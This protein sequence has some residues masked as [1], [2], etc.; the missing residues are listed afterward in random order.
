MVRYDVVRYGTIRYDVVRCDKI[1]YDV[2]RYEKIRYDVVR[3]GKIRYRMVWFLTI[4]PQP[5]FV[6]HCLRGL[7]YGCERCQKER[8]LRE[9]CG[10]EQ[11]VGSRLVV[12]GV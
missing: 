3:Y 1:R 5:P 8:C 4:P 12:S 6:R 7:V 9:P 10:W 11:I 2:V